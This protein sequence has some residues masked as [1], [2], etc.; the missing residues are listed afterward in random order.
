MKTP[1]R[2][3]VVG[4]HPDDDDLRFG[5]TAIKLTRAGH[6]VKFVSVCNG[7]CGHQSMDGAAL[8]K[9]RKQEA[10]ATLAFN[11]VCEYQV[12]DHND[13][14][15]MAD[16][17]T[18]KELIRIIRAFAPDVVLSHRLCDYHADHRN[19][20][21]LVLDTAY[22]VKVPLFVPDAPIP[23]TEPVYGYFWDE[24][25]DPRPPR[26]DAVVPIDDVLEQKCLALD[27]HV[28]Q[29]YEWLPYDSHLSPMPDREAMDWPARFAFLKEHFCV[30]YHRAALAAREVLAQGGVEA[31]YAEC[32]EYSPYGRKVT[33][34][35]FRAL[36]DVSQ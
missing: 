19:T 27:C 17:E 36:F 29:F 35:A 9:R 13:C 1:R 25:T 8:A 23:E 15:V 21:Q 26:I 2:F 30:R 16:L 31:Q 3:L 10:Q 6:Q 12:L 18:R 28:S 33:P 32:F 20:A 24:F 11:G 34:E 4:A 14:E 7:N 22:L 5:G